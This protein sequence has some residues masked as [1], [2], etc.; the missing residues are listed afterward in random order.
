M[1]TQLQYQSGFA[2]HFSTEAL[3][4]ALPE[5]R[6]SP[7]RPP[8]GLIAEQLSGSAFTAKRAENK[9][10]WLYRIRPSV[11]Q[12]GLFKPLDAKKIITFPQSGVLNPPTQLRWDPIPKEEFH[13]DFI[14]SLITI[15]GNGD[16]SMR[17][18]S[19]IHLYG[20][21]KAMGD[22]YFYNADGDLLIVAQEG[23]LHLKTECGQLGI[24]P[25]EIA[26]IPRGMKFQANPVGDMAL[27]YVLEL[28]GAHLEL[29]NLGPIG[30]NGL[31]NP[32]DFKSPVACYEEKQGDF[33]LQC[34]YAGRL[35]ELGIKHS[36]FDVVAWHGN[37]VP[38]KYDLRHFNTIG[39]VSFDH[40]DPSI[41]TVLTSQTD[42]EGIAD[43]DFVIF[44][45]R[46]MVGEDTFRPPYFHRNVMSEYM[47]LIY[48]VYDAKPCGGFQPGGGSLHNCMSSHG[49]ERKA[50][51]KAYQEDLKPQFQKD[52]LAFMFESS[53]I[54]QP[55]AFALETKALQSDYCH[56]WQDI[57]PTFDPKKR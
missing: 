2:N 23:G 57:Q 10:T 9:R 43:V 14:D 3:N 6:N 50:F 30:A 18:G 7:Q 42:R 22:K 4:G 21:K 28:Y 38:Y 44:P 5:G 13:G 54:Y 26:V 52:T 39:T 24:E 40:P 56:L 11:T 20:A 31:A 36:P 48:G 46:W 47:G 35:W 12:S 34:K 37:Y 49:P 32:R 55:T 51:E 45:E 1:D 41:F 53:W 33:K 15:A 17:V 16:A 25:G 27:G 29:P 8:Y 19:A